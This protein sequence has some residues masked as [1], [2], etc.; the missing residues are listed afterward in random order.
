MLVQAM[1]I[2]SFVDMRHASCAA[3]NAFYD[4]AAVRDD[5]DSAAYASRA[6]G[7]VNDY[8]CASALFQSVAN[9][10]YHSSSEYDAV[11]ALYR[12]GEVIG[13]NPCSINKGDAAFAAAAHDIIYTACKLH[14]VY[15]T[16]A[17][18][19]AASFSS[20]AAC[21]GEAYYSVAGALFLSTDH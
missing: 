14:A 2:S 19:R 15:H 20:I 4:A 11:A 17:V 18:L 7:Y 3:V 6:Y 5:A 8:Q 9:R 1:Q 12:C 21:N 10:T 13:F 16:A